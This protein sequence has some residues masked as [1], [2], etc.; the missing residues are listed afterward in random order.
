MKFRVLVSVVFYFVLS[1]SLQTFTFTAC[2]SGDS[3]NETF[4]NPLYR[5]QDPFIYKHSDNYYYYCEVKRNRLIV[6][7]SEKL[8]DRG[9]QKIVWTAPDEGWNT[10]EV[11]A[12][13]LHYVQGKWYIYYAADTGKNKYHR[14][15]VLESLSQD[16]QGEYVDKGMVYTGDEYETQ[17]NNRWGIDATPLEMNDNLYLIWSGWYGEDDDIQCIYIAPMSNPYTVIGNRIKIAEN[18][19]YI[20]ERL[21][22]NSNS[23]GLS[24]GPQILKNGGKIYLIYSCSGSWQVTYKLGQL[25]IDAKANPLEPSNWLKKNE[26]VFTGTSTVHGVGHG[27]FTKSPD[28]SEDWIIYH[29]KVDTVPGWKRDVRLQRFTWNTDGSPNFGIPVNPDTPLNLPSGEKK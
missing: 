12:P 26:P 22:D 21:D 23:K 18:D 29:S 1:A 9:D 27:S 11:W 10:S 15:G 24:E 16:P 2:V 5:G 3:K 17:T 25:S 20:W 14:V 7:K 6:W 4:T 28:N 8:T 13:E 19:D